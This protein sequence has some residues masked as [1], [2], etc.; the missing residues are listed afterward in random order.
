MSEQKSS[1]CT[2][3]A[4]GQPGCVTEPCTQGSSRA[5]WHSAGSHSELFLEDAGFLLWSPGAVFIS[6]HKM[7]QCCVFSLYK[8]VQWSS[9]PSNSGLQVW[10]KSRSWLEY[11]EEK[12]GVCSATWSE[13]RAQLRT[14]R[15]GKSYQQTLHCLSCFKIPTF[16]WSVEWPAPE[17][18]HCLISESDYLK[19]PCVSL[20]LTDNWGIFSVPINVQKYFASPWFFRG[21]ATTCG[22]CSTD[23]LSTLE[24]LGRLAELL[25]LTAEQ[26][27]SSTAVP[28]AAVLIV[29]Y[30]RRGLAIL[31]L[32]LT[33]V[34]SA[35]QMTTELIQLTNW[36][37]NHLHVTLSPL[38]G[39]RAWGDLEA[40][41]LYF[42]IRC[43]NT[44]GYC[45]LHS[46]ARVPWTELIEFGL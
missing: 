18:K 36:K 5:L 24:H 19:T 25:P 7:V 33:W 23:F 39:R 43:C 37:K 6:S 16:L 32:S 17:I 42:A 8:K 10:G 44:C 45:M 31:L 2:C 14:K 27:V 20:S 40:N 11:I 35:C 1:L 29:Q 15:K 41:S 34:F 30:Y 13:H 3:Q 21:V 38:A 12:Q 9:P 46:V 22:G 28:E 4:A 26:L